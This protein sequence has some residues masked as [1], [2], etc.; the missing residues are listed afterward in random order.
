MSALYYCGNSARDTITGSE[1]SLMLKTWESCGYGIQP[2]DSGY[3]VTF[4]NGYVR[5]YRS[6]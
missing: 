2:I 3:A 6:A 4:A 1:L 5:T